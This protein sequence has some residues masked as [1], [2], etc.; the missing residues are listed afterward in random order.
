MSSEFRVLVNN[1][2]VSTAVLGDEI[3]NIF[4]DLQ[5]DSLAVFISHTSIRCVYFMPNVEDRELS[6]NCW[7]ES[8]Q[9][10]GHLIKLID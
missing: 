8:D 3:W 5:R 6:K 4:A 10:K 7:R 2:E 9:H 1:W